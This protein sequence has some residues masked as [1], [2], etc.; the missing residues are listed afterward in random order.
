[1]ERDERGRNESNRE[2][3]KYCG[4]GKESLR[5]ET[6][7]KKK[8]SSKKEREGG[9]RKR[10]KLKNRNKIGGKGK[11]EE[12]EGNGEEGKNEEERDIC[13]SM[14]IGQ[15]NKTSCIIWY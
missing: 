11:K 13:E 5:K 8:K 12:G 10:S 14:G 9:R 15:D 7:R 4:E 1:M 3:V 2:G 6:G